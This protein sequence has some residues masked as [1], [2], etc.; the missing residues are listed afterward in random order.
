MSNWSALLV[1]ESIVGMGTQPQPRAGQG[2][3]V[4]H[5]DDVL[6]TYDKMLS[7]FPGQ[8]RHVQIRREQR[9]H[10]VEAGEGPPALLLHGTTNRAADASVHGP[11]QPRRPRSGV[12]SR[13]WNSEDLCHTCPVVRS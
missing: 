11:P 3:D 8:H 4:T 13:R 2:Q 12:R 10:V 5:S 6:R 9:V 1:N 7:P